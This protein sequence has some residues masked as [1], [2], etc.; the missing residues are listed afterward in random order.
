MTANNMLIFPII[1]KDILLSQTLTLDN[2]NKKLLIAK[3]KH[4]HQHQHQH[5]QKKQNLKMIW[6][7]VMQGE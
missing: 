6:S 4:H 3:H 7:H 1:H 5:Q 2:K